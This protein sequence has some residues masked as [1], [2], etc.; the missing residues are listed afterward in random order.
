M[1]HRV[2]KRYGM[3]EVLSLMH[4]IISKWFKSKFDS[5]TIPQSMAIP[6][7]HE[8]K[9]VLVSSPTGS[10]KTITGFL[11]I[12]NELFILASKGRLEDK[13]YCVYISPLK[14]LANDIDKNL[15]KPL[16][17]IKSLAEKEG[18]KVPKI[19]VAVRSGDTTPY[20]RQRMAVKPPHIFI[21]TPESISIIMSTPKFKRRFRDVRYVIVDEIH[22]VSS[23][24]R[25]V[26]LAVTLERLVEFVGEE[27]TRI[28]LSATQSP[29]EEIGKFLAGYN[30]KGKLRDI[31]IVEAPMDKKM[32]LKV[33]SPVSDISHLPHEVV[34]WKMYEMLKDLINN[35]KTTLIFTNTRSGTESVVYKLKELGLKKI[36]A[37]HGSLSKETRL[38]VED[39]LREGDLKAVSCSTSL[40]LGIDI[41]YID[42]VCQ[43]GSPKSIA[44]G[45]QR[46]GRAGHRIGETSKGRI[47]AFEN[48]DLVEC[49]VLVNK[50]YDG[51]IDRINI[52]RNSLDVLAQTIVGMSLERKWDAEEAYK[53]IRR[54]YPYRTLSKDDFYNVILYLTGMHDV[55][56]EGYSKI[57]YSPET[58]VFGKKKGTR[59]IYYLN[60]GTIPE[61][62]NYKVYSEAGAPL[63]NLSEKF[64]ER[65]RMGDIFVLG[66]KSYEFIKTRGMKVFVKDAQGKKPTVPSWAGEMLPRSF[67][68]SI[69]IGRFRATMEKMMNTKK[70]DEIIKYLVKYYHIND[71][72]AKSILTYFKEQRGV[73]KKFPTHKRI[74]IEGYIDLQGRYNIIFHYCFGKR[75]NDALSR[76]Y[77]YC[78]TERYK[79]N[80]SVSLTD[81]GFMIVSTKYIPIEDVVNLLTPDN[82]EEYLRKAI[83]NTEIFKQRFRHC[84]TR[85][86]MVL[87]NYKGRDVPI[88]KQVYHSQKILDALEKDDDF[89]IIKETYNEILHDSMDVEN[90]MYVIKGIHNGK[91]KVEL[92]DYSDTPSPFA[93]G[94]VLA[95]VS[96][97]VMMEDR[98]ALL[99]ELH[100]RVLVR[101][102]GEKIKEERYT[103][104]I[105]EKYYGTKRPV[106]DVKEDI[107]YLL[108]KL[109]PMNVFEERGE[110][111]F[112][113]SSIPHETLR[114]W[115]EELLEE[116][117]IT[118]IRTDG[119]NVWIPTE[120]LDIYITIYRKGKTL[121]NRE[122]K[123]LDEIR[124]RG[125][126]SKKGVKDIIKNLER[127]F[128]I[129]RT[130]NFKD[131]PRWKVRT[132]PKKTGIVRSEAIKSFIMRHISYFGPK[133]KEEIAFYLKLDEN[134]VDSALKELVMEGEIVSGIFM[135]DAKE[136]QYMVYK[137]K[138]RID[139]WSKRE[140]SFDEETVLDY[141]VK[142]QFRGFKTIEDYFERLHEAGIPFDV[143]NRLDNFTLKDWID[144]REKGEVIQ[145]RFSRGR[146]SYISKK[147]LPIYISA[148]RKDVLD[149]TDRKILDYLKEHPESTVLSMISAL[150][151][152][153]I[154]RQIIKERI[155]KLDRN[156]YVVRAPAEGRDWSTRNKYIALDNVRKIDDGK[157]ELMR[158]YLRA[159]GPA[160]V[161]VLR[162]ATGLPFD[163][164]MEILS[165]MEDEKEVTRISVIGK[166]SQE[167]FILSE[168]LKKLEKTKYCDRVKDKMRILSLHD[169]F[170]RRMWA[171]VI[172][173][174]GEGWMFPV[175]KNGKLCGVVEKWEMSGCIE[176]REILMDDAKYLEEL[177][178]EF[179]HIMEYYGQMGVDI[180][181]VKSVFGKSIDELDKKTLNIF[182]NH[183]Y[184]KI[185][186]M[187]VKGNVI[188][189][190]FS[191]DEVMAYIFYKQHIHPLSRFKSTIDA[192][193]G[194]GG[195]RSDFEGIIRCKHY[196]PLKK[197]W[198]SDMLIACLV[199][200]EQLTYCTVQDLFL[201]KAA[202]SRPI[203]DAM[204]KIID[205][206]PQ[207]GSISRSQ[208]FKK[209]DL[210]HDEFS[211]AL[212]ELYAG[213]Y[214]VRDS[215]HQFLKTRTPD[216]S[217]KDAR[218][219][220]MK[221]II[222]NFGI[223]SAEILAEYTKHEY[224]MME[225]RQML[226]EWE[227]NGYLVKGYLI[228]GD[229]TLYWVIKKD[230]D[231]L[232]KIDFNDTIILAPNDPI[233]HY[234]SKKIKEDFGIGTGFI[235]FRGTKMTS[236]FKGSRTGNTLTITLLLGTVEDE[237]LI[238]EF[239]Q[240]CGMKVI[241]DRTEDQRMDD[242]ELMLWFEKRKAKISK[243]VDND[244]VNN[245]EIEDV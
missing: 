11:S 107:L 28:G 152:S 175:V 211:D 53:V 21:T 202:K 55:D 64:V 69:E 5:L 228:E 15:Q 133:N 56:S 86:F 58:N 212:R 156:I 149:E 148:I 76:A 110:N 85:S 39:S 14:A 100:R 126:T 238:K 115:A 199:I 129:T 182:M 38:D 231:L 134:D 63:G 41:G 245:D 70:D 31:Y 140:E 146:V 135:E 147:D 208:L 82:F 13:I 158:I 207:F 161:N 27:F 169:P 121:N 163:E 204:K 84:A 197:Y 176:I 243:L 24:K 80:V 145:G 183:G 12:I 136:T 4:P 59:M 83:S 10:G 227:E 143:F 19:R 244:E 144:L 168:E 47:I 230:L 72:A 33:L 188:P 124:D 137:D 119:G 97:I 6:L 192:V 88:S 17:E 154:P 242:W 138:M 226:C 48:D 142:K 219:K 125:T 9:N 98:S 75:V 67:D 150:E 87:K 49:A 234:L 235:I 132:L 3:K 123:I 181:R 65:L 62:S 162:H 104:E 16:K 139:A 128:Y 36:A 77:A 7:I 233:S 164:V 8:R 122:R 25:G 224:K 159:H 23:S 18:I 101:V 103:K 173:R 210:G 214:I 68:L 141:V 187:L 20:E 217:Y 106:I 198:R 179:D 73:H 46:I 71:G 116:D 114:K 105:L 37:H 40:E 236:A 240:R 35:H 1:I 44:K 117:M 66:G 201:Y 89:P 94:I 51:K 189:Q 205:V 160:P 112:K 172:A 229:D 91:I 200:P 206:M 178:E 22:E 151:S 29:I 222:D 60:C 180:I 184:M 232:G 241:F 78:I 108:R 185:Q 225:I 52:L 32:D 34:T 223:V 165:Q 127:E 54:A 209:V 61:E 239:A 109:G 131:K 195:L 26:F 99:R 130:D 193:V 45:I 203:N 90:A 190:T 167:M 30:R 50:A 170:S 96:D 92:L 153:G 81:D 79:V 171:T 2:K 166:T 213:L 93:H 120:D 74:I 113:Y 102:M 186:N 174:F 196:V 215:K 111:I 42:L 237:N 216:I 157:R 177:I 220:V 57:W 218:K 221:R 118:H 95:G 43:I 194:M 155:E 191:E